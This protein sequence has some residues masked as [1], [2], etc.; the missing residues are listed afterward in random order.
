MLIYHLRFCWWNTGL[1]PAVKSKSSTVDDAQYEKLTTHIVELI[2]RKSCDL[3]ALCELSS[4]DVL[5]ITRRLRDI[6]PHYRVLD[7]TNKIQRTRYDVA[8]IYNTAK[9]G[10]EFQHDLSKI[11]TGNTVKAGQ[12]IRVDSIHDKKPIYV[13]LCHWASRLRSEG[14]EK[15][16]A[17]ARLVFES[18]QEY[19]RNDDYVV[20][21]GDFND[22][23]YDDSLTTHLNATRC[24][25]AVQKYPTDF[26]YNPFWRTMVSEH[27]YSHS[28]ET[29]S[30]RSGT[31]RFK[32]FAGTMW[33]SYD[34]MVFSGNFLK[35]GYWHLNEPRTHVI[36]DDS[37][38]A[39]YCSKLCFIDHLPIICE[40]TRP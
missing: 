13:Y 15:R 29:K 40:I 38:F 39:D 22:N 8:V 25:D 21:M 12:L 31:H 3:I 33:H 30:Y 27:L 10:V 2:L 18:S 23:P 37:L 32:Q 9:L 11:I 36:Y 24:L 4:D 6:F 19:I 5:H 20:V 14:K 35:E 34:Q 16:E 7:L 1:S 26:F 17:S 28:E